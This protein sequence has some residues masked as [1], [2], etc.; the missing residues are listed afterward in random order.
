MEVIEFEIA[1]EMRD[2]ECSRSFSR[3]VPIAGNDAAS[4]AGVGDSGAGVYRK[5]VIIQVITVRREVE[6]EQRWFT[7]LGGHSYAG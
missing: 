2:E 5:D 7:R 1:L 4:G 3:G 6:C